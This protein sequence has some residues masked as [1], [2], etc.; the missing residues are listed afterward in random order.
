MNPRE[1][2]NISESHENI[3]GGVEGELSNNNNHHHQKYILQPIRA[4]TN[5]YASIVC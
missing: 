1:M 4:D 3:S 5:V 2:P